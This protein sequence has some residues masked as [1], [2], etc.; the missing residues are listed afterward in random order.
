TSGSSSAPVIS[1]ASVS[2]L[3]IA[4][5]LLLGMSWAPVTVLQSMFVF[6][7]FA[8][9]TKLIILLGLAAAIAMSVKYLEQESIARFEYPVLVLLAGLGMMLMVS[10][11]N[12][13]ALYV[14]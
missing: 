12:L 6:D 13:L 14:G 7:H 2:A 5:I 4:V 3:A 1:W 9:F 11:N 8:G 10:A